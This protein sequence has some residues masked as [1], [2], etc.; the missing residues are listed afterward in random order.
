MAMMLRSLNVPL[1]T[2]GYDRENQR[3]A[4]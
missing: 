1:A 2:I 3:W 4:E